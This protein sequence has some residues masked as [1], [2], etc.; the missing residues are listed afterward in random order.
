MFERVYSLVMRG[1]LRE[2]LLL[3]SAAFAGL[4]DLLDAF[5]VEPTPCHAGLAFRALTSLAPV[6][7]LCHGGLDFTRELIKN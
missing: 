1:G 4:A 5:R 7:T 6:P 2:G 3:F